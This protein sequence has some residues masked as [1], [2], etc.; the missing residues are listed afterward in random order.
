[1]N[2]EAFVIIVNRNPIITKCLF[3]FSIA[4]FGITVFQKFK[5]FKNNSNFCFLDLNLFLNVTIKWAST[6]LKI[7]ER[8]NKT[9]SL[10]YTTLCHSVT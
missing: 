6:I 5:V 8:K 9:R 2:Y 7:K 4:H 3:V 10:Q 1:M